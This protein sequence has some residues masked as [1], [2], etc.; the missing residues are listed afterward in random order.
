MAFQAD[1]SDPIIICA[2]STPHS[3]YTYVFI[4]RAFLYVYL[5]IMIVCTNIYIPFHS[6]GLPLQC[7]IGKYLIRPQ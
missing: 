4:Q 7:F 3:P 6:K 1:Y 5:L 2:T